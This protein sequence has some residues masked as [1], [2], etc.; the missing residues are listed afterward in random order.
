MKRVVGL[1]LVIFLFIVGYFSVWGR[2]PFAPVFDSSM[3]PALQEGSLLIIKSMD[4]Q[5]LKEGD[6][7][8]YKVPG[9]IRETYHYPPVVIRR[10][11]E[12]KKD[13]YG[14]WIRTQADNT[15]EDPFLIRPSDIR[16][17]IR[18][19]I[20]YL[21]L[22]LFLFQNEPATIFVA[23]LILLLALFLYSKSI[24]IYFGRRFRTFISPIVEENHQVN[25]V[26]S[27]RFE[28]TEKALEG[29]AN[30]MQQYAQHLA[31]HTSAIQGLSEASQ[32]LKVSAAEQNRILSQL[33]K[34][35]TQ[36][37]SK[38]ELSKIQGVVHDFERRT[39]E[40]LQA[41]NALENE[42]QVQSPQTHVE[43]LLTEKVQAPQGCAVKIKALLT[44]THHHSN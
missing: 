37:R 21:G 32:S 2:L 28:A 33:T 27:N 15:N 5:S 41:K 31:S 42:I 1:I 16:G 3:G 10:V 19:Q 20:P 44:R 43:P 13:Q 26:L 17:I 24:I 29:F 35:Y 6:I 39:R 34:V 12:L 23:I 9:L 4:A 14:T 38:E 7:V 22:S 30:A 25:L 40:A 11:I 8:I 36:Q 18:S